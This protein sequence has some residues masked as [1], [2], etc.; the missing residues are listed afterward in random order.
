MLVVFDS[1]VGVHYSLVYF[2]DQ[3]LNQVYQFTGF[4]QCKL[5]PIDVLGVIAYR[6]MFADRVKNDVQC[7]VQ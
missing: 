1:T 2:A 3:E 7:L 4:F 6:G 5:L